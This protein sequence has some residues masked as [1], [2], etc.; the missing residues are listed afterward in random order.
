MAA[1]E[2]KVT[3]F[4]WQ[5]VVDPPAVMVGVGGNGLTVTVVAADVPLQLLASVTVTV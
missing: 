4:P 2:V 3:L 5:K 1:L